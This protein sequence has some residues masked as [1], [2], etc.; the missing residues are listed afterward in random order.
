M[1]LLVGYEDHDPH[2]GM[3]DFERLLSESEDCRDVCELR[4][5]VGNNYISSENLMKLACEFNTMSLAFHFAKGIGRDIDFVQ[6]AVKNG[7]NAKAAMD[8]VR[9]KKEGEK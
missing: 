3:I 1:K 4:F 6:H 7:A 2:G 5:C 9:A 8:W